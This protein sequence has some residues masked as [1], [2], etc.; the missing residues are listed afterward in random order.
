VTSD[1]RGMVDAAAIT[2]VFLYT[3]DG[4]S[5]VGTRARINEPFQG[6]RFYTP[7]GVTSVGTKRRHP[8][9]VAQL[10]FLYA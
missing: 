10:S 6:Q 8:K 1:G 5:P 2:T 9:R 4:M 3:P 7:D